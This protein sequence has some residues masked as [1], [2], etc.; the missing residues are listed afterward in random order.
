[1]TKG[2]VPATY[3]PIFASNLALVQDERNE[4]A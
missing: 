2:H 3:Q 4:V 1:M